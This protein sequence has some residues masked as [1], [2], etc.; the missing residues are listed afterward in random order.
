LE[1]IAVVF[2]DP[3]VVYA[4]TQSPFKNLADA[5][6]YAKANPGKAKWGAANPASLE[7]IALEQ[8]N[9]RMGLRAPVVC[10]HLSSR[11]KAGAIS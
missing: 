11:M 2:Y 3:E 7:R 8:L 9:R 4:R 6:A 1:P 5:V 10:A